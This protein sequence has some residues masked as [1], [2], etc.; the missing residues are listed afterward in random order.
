[1]TRIY[2]PSSFCFIRANG[3]CLYFLIF[4]KVK[5][6]FVVS[7]NRQPFFCFYIR[8][9]FL[10]HFALFSLVDSL[11]FNAFRRVAGNLFLPFSTFLIDEL[12]WRTFVLVVLLHV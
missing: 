12:A 2:P 5:M 11:K 6:E 1:M 7:V 8:D 4:A 10:F 9:F 3:Q